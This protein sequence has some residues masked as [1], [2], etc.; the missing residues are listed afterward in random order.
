[1]RGG[2]TAGE[3]T[4]APPHP[5]EKQ[6]KGC[7]KAALVPGLGGGSGASEL[8]EGSVAR[9]LLPRTLCP[10]HTRTPSSEENWKRR[11]LGWRSSEGV[12]TAV[13]AG[14]RG[15]GANGACAWRGRPVRPVRPV[16][17]E[18][19]ESSASRGGSGH[20][21]AVGGAQAGVRVLLTAHSLVPLLLPPPR[22]P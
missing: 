15:A 14:T 6:K 7:Q 17:R 16:H 8:T 22:A 5:R 9:M 4:A 1:M 19:R 10:T 2:Q 11:D 20:Q 12:L 18:C 13:F 3:D 21:A